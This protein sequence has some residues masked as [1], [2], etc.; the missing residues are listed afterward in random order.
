MAPETPPPPREQEQSIKAR[1]SELFEKKTADTGP[2]KSFSKY[3]GET[4]TA[5]FSKSEKVAL[6]TAAAVVVLLFG[7]TI[8]TMKGPPK[9]RRVYK[10][11]PHPTAVQPA[12]PEKEKATTPD[13]EKPAVSEKAKAATPEKTK[14]ATPKT[15]KKAA[16]KS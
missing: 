16:A 11:A 13:K 6:W 12:T 14:T 3:L 15:G 8:V 10:T 9:K 4:P 2:R 5:P 7:A 1:K